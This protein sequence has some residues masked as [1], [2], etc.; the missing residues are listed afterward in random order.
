MDIY[1]TAVARNLRRLRNIVSAVNQSRIN[2]L[3]QFTIM[4][5][6]LENITSNITFYNDTYID[7]SGYYDFYNP[8]DKLIVRVLFIICYSVVFALCIC[9]KYKLCIFLKAE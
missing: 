9:G 3:I 7:S 2:A 5:S 8:F 6:N 1:V 4:A